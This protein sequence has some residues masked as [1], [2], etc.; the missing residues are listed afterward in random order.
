MFHSFYLAWQYI[1]FYKLRSTILVACITLIAFLPLSLQLLLYK[2]EALLFE[3]ANETPLLLGAN[4]SP[5]DLVLNSLYFDDELPR[6]IT[7]QAEERIWDSEL[8][9]AI[10]LYVRFKSRSA[11]IVGTTLDY[12]EFRHLSLSYGR[13]MGLLGET[14]IGANVAKRLKLSIGDSLISSP[15]TVFDLAG[16]YPLKMNIVGILAPSFTMDDEAVFVDIKTTWI[17][18]GLV[19][20]H[21]DVTQTSD[22]SVILAREKGTVTANAKLMHYNEITPENQSNFHIHGDT[23]QYPLTAVIVLPDDTKSGTLL[24]G[25]LLNDKNYQLVKPLTIIVGLMANIFR[26]KHMIDGV[27]LLVGLATLLAIFLVFSLSLRLRE[28]EFET[29]FKIGGNRLTTAYLM[30]TEIILI[31]LIS[32]GLCIILL[33]LVELYSTD[34]VRLLIIQ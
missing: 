28:K 8:A 4:S 15:E 10:P 22:Q 25:R 32:L 18:E 7:Q 29:V 5:L 13:W 33:K 3:R 11:P 17:I 34:I 26:I 31:G 14:V 6:L 24:R 19:H 20:G 30:V 12:F 2:S 27:V 23:T 9:S 21:D 16:V 1:R